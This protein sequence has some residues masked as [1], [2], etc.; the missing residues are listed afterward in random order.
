MKKGDFNIVNSEFEK[1]LG[2]KYD[3]KLTFNNHY[4][5][6]HFEMYI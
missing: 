5:I 2:V 4:F 3:F 1:L 6:I